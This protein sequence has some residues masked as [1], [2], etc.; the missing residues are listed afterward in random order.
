MYN[1]GKLNYL[2]YT[3]SKLN[4]PKIRR[5][6]AT[7]P[8]TFFVLIN[9]FS[10][11]QLA[12]AFVLQKDSYYVHDDTDAFLISLLQKDFDIYLETFFVLFLLEAFLC[13]FL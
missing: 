3:Q 6:L 7:K 13:F 5:I 1:K 12:F 8:I 11:T 10:Y 4:C 2:C 9:S